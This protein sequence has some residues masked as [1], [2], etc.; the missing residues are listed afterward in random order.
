MQADLD[1][2]LFRKIGP[3]GPHDYLPERLIEKEAGHDCR[4]S[5]VTIR[6]YL[7]N[8]GPMT[9]SGARWRLIERVILGDPPGKKTVCVMWRGH[10]VENDQIVREGVVVER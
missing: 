4:I 7:V 3:F 9:A 2:W 8:P 1:A 10:R 5:P 6:R